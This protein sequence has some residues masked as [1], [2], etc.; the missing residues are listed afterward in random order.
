M[1]STH[2]NDYLFFK[3]DLQQVIQ[4]H[5]NDLF[6]E[7]DELDEDRLLNTNPDEL[8]VHFTAKFI[9]NPPTLFEDKIKVSRK[10]IKLNAYLFIVD[11]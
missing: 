6:Q 2:P 7:L 11:L 8:A 4:N 1:M 10:N 3:R 9:L 5:Q